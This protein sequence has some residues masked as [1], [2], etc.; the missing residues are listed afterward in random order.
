MC[1]N[2]YTGKTFCVCSICWVSPSLN[3]RHTNKFPLNKKV[4]KF[5]VILF[6]L[7]VLILFFWKVEKIFNDHARYA[8]ENYFYSFFLLWIEFSSF[9]EPSFSVSPFFVSLRDSIRTL[10]WRNPLN[11]ISA[12]GTGM[13]WHELHHKHIKKSGICE[14][15]LLMCKI[16]M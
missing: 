5:Y 13:P 7:F 3:R 9:F 4:N 1:S 10:Y 16:G 15:L 11:I 8:W 14:L 6:Q 12:E 2:I